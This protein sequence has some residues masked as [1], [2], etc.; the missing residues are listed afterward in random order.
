[1]STTSDR[2]DPRLT[3]GTDTEPVDQA[4]AYLV[5]TDEERAR[6]FVR[7]LRL[8][9]L[10][11]ACGTRTTMGRA[12]AETYAA[13]PGFYGATYCVACRMHL[14]VGTAG[15]FV[16]VDRDGTVTDLKVGA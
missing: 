14:P 13:Q 16:W 4:E 2:N 3:R 9:Y 1:M 6:R 11:T 12:I 5:L 15:E 7:P 8:T 10:H